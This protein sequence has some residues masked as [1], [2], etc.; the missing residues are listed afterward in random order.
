[1][2]VQAAFNLTLFYFVVVGE[3]FQVSLQ[4]FLSFN[5]LFLFRPSPVLSLPQDSW[6]ATQTH[7]RFQ[8]AASRPCS[9][10]SFIQPTNINNKRYEYASK[11]RGRNCPR[12]FCQRQANCAVSSSHSYTTSACRITLT[13]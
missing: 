6:S 8:R 13:N 7:Y 4:A 9:T 11:N 1:M 10:Q 3:E 5:P 12:R 2:A